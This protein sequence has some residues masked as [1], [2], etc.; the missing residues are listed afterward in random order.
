MITLPRPS[1]PARRSFVAL[2][3]AA[4]LVCAAGCGSSSPQ[5]TS[6]AKQTSVNKRREVGLV[7]LAADYLGIERA[8]IRHAMREGKTL[9]EIAN[10]T[11]GHSSKGLL[12][13]AVRAR[14]ETLEA[15]AAAGHLSQ[16]QVS[17]RVEAVRRRIELRLDH[18]EPAEV[19]VAL[20]AA[21]DYLGLPAAQLDAK[22]RGGKSLAQIANSTPGRSAQGLVAAI[23]DA[24]QK[25]LRGNS[26][27]GAAPA[28]RTE[29]EAAARR[30]VDVTPREPAAGQHHGSSEHAAGAG[31][32]EGEAES[33]LSGAAREGG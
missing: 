3:A 20:K 8:K 17:A 21:T 2:G 28:S 27:P 7:E 16:Q 23:V 6:S 30:F 22:R 4:V 25:A 14:R 19:G 13:Y 12:E 1:L 9:A 33:G 26:T 5:T 31:A 15:R 18:Q 29:L 32:G 24:E 11:S 10:S